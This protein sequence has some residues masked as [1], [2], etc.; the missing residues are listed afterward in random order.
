MHEQIIFEFRIINLDENAVQAKI[1]ERDI[2]SEF[3]RIFDPLAVA[4]RHFFQPRRSLKGPL[5][6]RVTRGYWK[7]LAS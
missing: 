3:A 6:I 7:G 5:T 4:D 2:L 1:T